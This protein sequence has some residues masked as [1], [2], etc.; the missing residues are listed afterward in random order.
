MRYDVTGQ[1]SM[2]N[3]EEYIKRLK[4]L[5]LVYQNLAKDYEECL[6]NI[7]TNELI[8]EDTDI[9]DEIKALMEDE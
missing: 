1:W 9:W 7:W 5:C 2:E 8:P 4:S 6:Q 3:K